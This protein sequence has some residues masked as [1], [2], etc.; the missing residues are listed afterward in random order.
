MIKNHSIT[1]D[2]YVINSHLKKKI[3]VDTNREEDREEIEYLID[4]LSTKEK[5][6]IL[7]E[8]NY[9]EDQGQYIE[10]LLTKLTYK[11]NREEVTDV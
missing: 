3:I 4:L 10:R 11:R 7:K 9:C 5:K 2:E 1:V 6:Q 8:L